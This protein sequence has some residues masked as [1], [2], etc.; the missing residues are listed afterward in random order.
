MT[1]EELLNID[2]FR[3]V[4]LKYTKKAFEMLPKIE[5]PCILDIGCGN[6]LPTLKLMELSE[7]NFVGIDIDRKALEKFKKKI[8]EKGLSDR[9]K[10]MNKS[11]YNTN[12]PDENFDILWEEGVLHIL[13]LNK[14]LNECCRILKPKGF[15]VAFE[16][17]KWMHNSLEIFQDHSFQL[18][19]H[20]MLPEKY[21]WTGYYAPLEKKITELR[22]K[23]QGSK[24][25]EFLKN[26]EREVAM[27]KKNPKE[28]DCGFYIMQK[29]V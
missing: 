27:V 29:I 25:L 9:I 20:F 8:E 13:D 19:D 23:Y 21:W 3:A 2:Q 7:G 22:Q 28:F 26:Y 1:N 16:T 10:I 18:K 5:K 17:I 14:S 4:F 12:F 15:L 11:L 6:G 24:N